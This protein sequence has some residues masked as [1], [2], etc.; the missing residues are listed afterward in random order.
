MLNLPIRTRDWPRSIH[1]RLIQRL[2]E[3]GA[4]AIA[5][6]VDF[7]RPQGSIADLLA[8]PEAGDIDFKIPIRQRLPRVADFS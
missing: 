5:F 4:T 6:D 1:A 8:M 2:V 7:A 3:Q